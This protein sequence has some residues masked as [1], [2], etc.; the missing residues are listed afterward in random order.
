MYTNTATDTIN[1]AT[2]FLDFFEVIDGFKEEPENGY[3]A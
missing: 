1:N 3:K 2:I